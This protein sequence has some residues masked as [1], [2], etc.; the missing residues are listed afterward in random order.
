MKIKQQRDISRLPVW[1]HELIAKLT[2]ERDEARDAQKAYLD[3]QTPSSAWTE[4]Y[5][6]N[7]EYARRYIQTDA[8]TFSL[9][10][11]KEIS[12]QVIQR[13]GMTSPHL[14]I[15]SYLQRLVIL[16]DVSNGITLRTER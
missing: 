13:P 8:V 3:N 16:P 6:G 14:E 10:D 15:R 12:V 2:R 7:M 1:A 11:N 5:H 4:E 9:G